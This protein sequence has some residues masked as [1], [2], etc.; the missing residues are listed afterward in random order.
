MQ[1]HFSSRGGALAEAAAAKARAGRKPHAK[2]VFAPQFAIPGTSLAWPSQG[3]EIMG[4]Y[5]TTMK[6]KPTRRSARRSAI[7][8]H[9][10]FVLTY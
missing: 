6:D 7:K 9:R 1:R 5:G 8:P 3:P 2:S 4:N 10:L